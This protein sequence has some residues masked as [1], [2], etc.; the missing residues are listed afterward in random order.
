MDLIVLVC[1]IVKSL[2]SAT[3]GSS[4][5]SNISNFAPAFARTAQR[6]R[7]AIIACALENDGQPICVEN[8]RLHMACLQH[9]GDMWKPVVMTLMM[10]LFQMLLLMSW[11]LQILHEYIMVF[12]LHRQ[13]TKMTNK[14]SSDSD[15]ER[16]Q[17]QQSEP[18]CIL[19]GNLCH[20]KVHARRHFC[21]LWRQNT[22]R[23]HS[24]PLWKS[25]SRPYG[26]GRK[27]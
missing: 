17:W 12:V 1:K 9:W 23:Q 11:C 16:Q 8:T 25:R 19:C 4:K 27:L 3:R 10:M 15:T 22:L 13:I 20:A 5:T 6:T 21:V 7:S 24:Q 2:G 18:S 14:Y 26:R